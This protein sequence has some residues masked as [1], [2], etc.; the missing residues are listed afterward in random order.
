MPEA[1]ADL[2]LQGVIPRITERRA[3]ERR[4][5]EPLWVGAQGLVQRLR[6]GE[7]GV[8]RRNRRESARC[9][10][11]L[12]PREHGRDL[13]IDNTGS[14]GNGLGEERHLRCI[15]SIKAIRL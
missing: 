6:G 13:R 15:A 1:P 12:H 9:L 2:Q 8:D 3:E 5:A 14:G 4:Y 7:T 11:D 10:D